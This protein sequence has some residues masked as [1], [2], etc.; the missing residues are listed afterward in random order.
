MEEAAD[1]DARAAEAAASWHVLT[2]DEERSATTILGPRP[3]YTLAYDSETVVIDTRTWPGS[4]VSRVLRTGQPLRVGYYELR[5][6]SEWKVARRFRRGALVPE[7]RHRLCDAGFVLPDALEPIALGA[8]GLTPIYGGYEATLAT[9]RQT[10][11][12]YVATHRYRDGSKDLQI[13]SKQEFIR[14]VLYRYCY[15]YGPHLIGARLIGHHLFFDLTRLVTDVAADDGSLVRG[16]RRG[17]GWARRGFSLKLCD[18]PFEDCGFHPRIRVTKLGRF[19]FRSAFQKTSVPA[20]RAAQHGNQRRKRDYPGRFLDT[21]PFGLALR[22]CKSASLEAMGEVF[23]ARVRKRP[24]P[25]FA[26]PL[27]ED[28]LSYLVTDVR[29]TYWLEVAE[30]ADFRHLG[31]SRTPESIYSTASLAKGFQRAFGFPRTGERQWR[32]DLPALGYSAEAIE[33]VA[34]TTYFGGRAE[35]RDRSRVA[36]VLHLDFKSQYVA[37]SDLMGLQRYWC[38]KAVTVRECTAELQ[39]WLASKTPTELLAELRDPTTWRRL[40][41]LVCLCPDGG[42]TLPVRGDFSRSLQRQ[43]TDARSATADRA[44]SPYTIGQ[45]YIRSEEPLWYTLAEVLAGIIRDEVV[46]TLIQA[47]QVVPGA[48]QVE[49]HAVTIAGRAI[50]PLHEVV[51]TAFIDHRREVKRA[52]KAAQARDDLEEAGRLDGHQHALKEIALAGNYGVAEEL[53]EKIYEGRALALEVYALGRHRRYGQVVEEPGPYYAGV[54]GSFIPAAGRLLLAMCERLLR[55]QGLF[56]VFMD[57]DSVTPIR[58]PSMPREEFER[59]V[60]HVVACFADLNPFADGGSLL[61]YEE[62]NF[63]VDPDHPNALAEPNRHEPLY[64][65][66]TSAKRYVEFNGTEH[67][68]TGEQRPILRKFTS[69]GLG[70]W[71]RRD[72][73]TY[74]LPSYMDPPHTFRE[75]QD[76]QGNFMRVPDSAP[77]GGPLWVYRLQWDYAYTLL[78]GHYPTGD[79]LYRDEEGVPWYFLQHEDWLD[80]P[81]FYQ[82][83][84]ETW[85]DWQRIKHLPGLRPGGFL[86]VYPS[87]D[88]ARDPLSRMVWGDAI[89]R[90]NGSGGH[91]AVDYEDSQA[92]SAE[93]GEEEDEEAAAEHLEHVLSET[94]LTRDATALFS[95]YVTSAAA[96]AKALARGDIRR[97]GDETPVPPDTILKSMYA[98]VTHYFTHG[99][100]KAANPYGVGVLTRRHI[101]VCGVDVIGKES[102][103]LAQSAAEDTANVVG[104]QQQFGS[105]DYGAASSA[106]APTAP[107]R[108]RSAPE[109]PVRTRRRRLSSLFDED[110]PDLLAASRLSRKTIERVA[111]TAHEPLPETVAAL[112]RAMHLL[113]PDHLESISGW[114]EVVSGEALADLLGITP[115]QAQERLRGR[116]MWTTDERARLVQ[117]MGARRVSH[118]DEPAL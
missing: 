27:T 54:L 49:T 61:A 86:T 1:L 57:T 102:N 33:G 62:Q 112:E 53:N 11:E 72:Q 35:V 14:L 75:A 118:T 19:K 108:M 110:L 4:D 2:P 88:D 36:E 45:A 58:P 3:W 104:G 85:A 63:A 64:C 23:G 78:N 80:A 93:V 56:Y 10:V 83:S 25:E 15:G 98:V 68:E 114:R 116:A 34:A 99:E 91:G 71:G 32:L 6:I 26:G 109:D 39:A 12:A 9:D 106:W 47:L 31:L 8:D 95:P 59:R 29:A 41:V 42:L 37:G 28:Y 38:A 111:H 52:A 74:A 65:L 50:D 40:P 17:G 96:V 22:K 30:L 46:P 60:Q 55:D 44:P 81:A 115:E 51:W 97:I 69:H 18:C 84:I 70:Q 117:H 87:P 100:A 20:Q 13:H 92:E 67:P 94:L 103:R 101:E 21:M 5:G 113:A 76:A 48:D 107:S 73:D 16:V 79:P 43:R 105:R 24:H 77:L 66:A 82:F 7:D 90:H 89:V